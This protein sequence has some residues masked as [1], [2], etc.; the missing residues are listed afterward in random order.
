MRET[1]ARHPRWMEWLTRVGYV[2][3]GVVYLLVGGTGLF[4]AVG[5]SER[6]RGSTD[7]IRL[8]ARLPM[9]RVLIAALTV[10][11]VGYSLLSFVAAV[12]APE[13]EG[14]ARGALARAADAVAGTVYAALAALA[15]RLLADPTADTGSASEQWAARLLAMP[16]GR[17]LMA[18]A[19]L[20]AA[21][22]GLYLG[23]RA[24]ALPVTSQLERRRVAP[25]VVRGVVRLARVG[26]AARAILFVLCGGLLLRAGWSG[27]PRRVGGLGDALDTLADAPGGT[28][29]VG[30]VA[31]GCV[32]YGAYQLAKARWRRVRLAPP[33]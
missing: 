22:A 32:A 19:G 30:I 11:L 12:R 4:V 17:V 28:A 31:M 20:A 23:Y 21:G 13:G 25:A 5:L 7:V 26:L 14:G 10:G 24:L 27:E 29:I 6:A 1:A 18:L 15:V 33:E 16:G 9:G 3:R 8:L 2:A